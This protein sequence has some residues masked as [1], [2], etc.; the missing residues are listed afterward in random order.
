M[1]RGKLNSRPLWRTLHLDGSLDALIQIHKIYS[2]FFLLLFTLSVYFSFSLF[3]AHSRS[4]FISCFLSHIHQCLHVQILIRTHRQTRRHVHGPATIP[5]QKAGVTLASP[6]LTPRTGVS[7]CDRHRRGIEMRGSKRGKH[8][9]Q[10]RAAREEW[11]HR[12]TVAQ[13]GGYVLVTLRLDAPST[14]PETTSTQRAPSQSRGNA[15]LSPP[16]VYVNCRIPKWA[17]HSRDTRCHCCWLNQARTA[18]F[19]SARALLYIC[20]TKKQSKSFYLFIEDFH[21]RYYR[22]NNDR[23]SVREMKRWFYSI[24]MEYYAPR[25]VRLQFSFF[26]LHRI[27]V[28]YINAESLILASATFWPY[29]YYRVNFIIPIVI[30]DSPQSKQCVHAFIGDHGSQVKKG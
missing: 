17:F 1:P 21:F 27:I 28:A 11:E 23:R 12:P 24:A 3:P 4:K 2:F 16:L 19:Q 10:W 15:R 14:S 5:N 9:A 22:I 20:P 18:D 25:Q 7:G 29:R 30:H 13:G 6:P 26:Y 8:P